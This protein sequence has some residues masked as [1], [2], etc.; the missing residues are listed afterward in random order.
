M[1]SRRIRTQ[2]R[3]QR[4]KGMD[5]GHSRAAYDYLGDLRDPQYDPIF[6]IRYFEQN[7]RRNRSESSY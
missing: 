1:D 2:F 3:I 4:E 6:R 7:R 5:E